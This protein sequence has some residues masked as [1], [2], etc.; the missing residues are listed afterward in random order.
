[1][2]P[3]SNP[4]TVHEAPMDSEWLL[5]EEEALPF[6]TAEKILN[7]TEEEKY[8][9][10]PPRVVGWSTRRKTWSQFLVSKVEN[11]RK[12]NLSIFDKELEL[13]EATKRM[14]RHTLFFVLASMYLGSS[15][16]CF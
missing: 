12:A 11:A 3:F 9:T 8:L 6:D 14:V 15:Y 10:A 16:A 7:E 4:L 5:G 13:D 1:M 2:F